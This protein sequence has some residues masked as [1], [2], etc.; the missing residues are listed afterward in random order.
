MA[1][2]VILPRV[3]MDM[4]EGRISRWFVA[5]GQSVAKGQPIFEIETDKA[6]MEVEAPAAGVIR[7]LTDALDT[8]MPV[9]SVV[10]WIEGEGDPTDERQRPP[11]PL[12]GEGAPKDALRASVLC[13]RPTQASGFAVSEGRERGEHDAEGGSP[14]PDPTSSGHPLPRGERALVPGSPTDFGAPAPEELRATPLA[15]RLARERGID[16]AEL[17]G[18][19]PKGRI[20]AA[21]IEAL[22]G[23][24][25]TQAAGVASA[26]GLHRQWLRRGEGLPLVLLH[27]FGGDLNA[28]RL[29]LATA[30]PSCPVLGIDLPGHG[31]SAARGIAGF[32]EMV[33][34]VADALMAEGLDAAHLAGHSLGAAAAAALV[35]RGAV[36]ARS[37]LLIA[38]AGLGPDMNGA[39]IAGFLRARSRASLAPWIDELVADP[40]ALGPS[41]LEATLRQRSEPSLAGLEAAAAVLFPDGTQGFSVRADLERL[42]IPAKIVF[43]TD[44][45]IIPSRHARGL[46]GRIAVHLFRGIGHMPHFEAREDIA[47]LARELMRAG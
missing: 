27:G 21:D 13:R 6:A 32:D 25:A 11:S 42:S 31:G 15:R 33:G 19:G 16:L 9:G 30:R 45:R 5:E 3:D 20:Q 39:F 40:A 2:E 36:A 14:S 23:G 22:A 29:F 26:G 24:T 35:G 1:T 47:A 41:F 4:A 28:W 10:A 34:A 38:P 8:A 43:G 12:T 17:S 7:G 37:L 46:P 44:D 18:S